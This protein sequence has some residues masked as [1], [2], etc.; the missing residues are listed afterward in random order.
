MKEDTKLKKIR[1]LAQQRTNRLDS[2]FG[3]SLPRE[4]NYKWHDVYV[5]VIEKDDYLILKSGAQLTALTKKI[6][7]ANS[8]KQE[9]VYI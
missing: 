6:L 5:K 7:K 9:E 2:L 8:K 1:L 3:V 4:L